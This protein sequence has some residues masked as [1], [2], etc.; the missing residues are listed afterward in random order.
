MDSD[1]V[2]ADAHRDT[3]V[4][5]NSFQ[6]Y[7]VNPNSFTSNRDQQKNSHSIDTIYDG[8]SQTILFSENVNAGNTGPWAAGN[9]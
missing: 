7:A 3:A 5:W 4:F 8:C 1:R 9:S 2:D 6:K